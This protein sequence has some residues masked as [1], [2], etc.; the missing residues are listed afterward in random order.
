MKN[1]DESLRKKKDNICQICKNDKITINIKKIYDKRLK[2]IINEINKKDKDLSILIKKCNCQNNKDKA[3]KICLLLNIIFNFDL[4][5]DECK[6]EYNIY[7][8]K[9]KKAYKKCCYICSFLTLLIFHMILSAGAIFLVLYIH[10]INKNIKNNFE[11]NKFYHIYYFFA[12]AI[13]IINTIIAFITF[14]N[15]LDKNNKDI[16]EYNLQVKDFNETNK[17]HKKPE[18]YELLYKYYRFFYN[19]QIRYLI[20]KK[21]KNVFMSKGFG[22]FNKELQEIMNKNNKESLEDNTFNNGG[23]DIL[24]INKKSILKAKTSKKNIIINKNI[25]TE[26]SNGI[27]NNMSFKKASSPIKEE[28]KNNDI[29][30]Q[31]D[32]DKD[33][34]K[35]LISEKKSENT[36]LDNYKENKNIDNIGEEENNLN[37]INTK[38]NLIEEEGEKEKEKDKKLKKENKKENDDIET[39]KF[40]NN[41]NIIIGE[42]SN[43]KNSVNFYNKSIYSDRV[44]NQEEEKIAKTYFYKKINNKNKVF[45]KSNTLINPKKHKNKKKKKEKEKQEN[46]EKQEK[47]EKQEKNEKQEN[48]IKNKLKLRVEE[49]E[50]KYIDSTFL[51][52][53]EKSKIEEKTKIIEEEPFDMFISMPFHN[54]GK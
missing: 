15:F 34:D 22:N 51:V 5:C 19:T 27:I 10:I 9:K 37:I 25:I 20:G 12:G 17:K 30:I 8:S 50:K 49:S 1:G 2:A 47:T 53:D 36:N 21:Q 23:E 11:E 7:I 54:N 18:L 26:Q 6:T 28:E 31:K 39:N 48:K 44:K 33:K 29:L 42:K 24:N 14:T 32:K 3:H 52:K 4:K 40:D 43:I 46:E 41:E 45:G 13:I 35:E 38:D 16:S